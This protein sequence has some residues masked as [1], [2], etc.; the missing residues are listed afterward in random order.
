MNQL[1]NM[2][3]QYYQFF[4]DNN[5]TAFLDLLHEDIIHDI[6]QGERQV[7]KEKFLTFMQR[8]NRCY[9][10]KIDNLIIMTA[11][12]SCH[13]AAEFRVTGT[14]LATDSGLPQARNQSY[15]LLCGA[16]FEMKNDK[17]LRVTNYYNLNE[18]LKQI[19]E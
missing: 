19:G 1:H 3:H 15:S 5:L 2:I 7:G 18:W 11:N 17:I 4:N 9:K 16:F 12:D 14:Y 6:N 13:T 10:E 8:M